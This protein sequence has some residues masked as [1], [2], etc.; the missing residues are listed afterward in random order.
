[1]FG[2]LSTYLGK[3]DKQVVVSYRGFRSTKHY[4]GRDPFPAL[5]ANGPINEQN[6][7]NVDFTYALTS[8]WN[9]SINVPLHFNSFSVRRS[10]PVTR[11][12]TWQK[13]E[14]SGAGDII[15]RV[16]YWTMSTE[17]DDHNIGVSVGVKVPTGKANRTDQVFTRTVPVDV[18]VQTGDKGWGVTAGAQGFQRIK[19]ATIYGS[20]SYLINPRNTNGVPTF[21]GSL[22]NPNN[23]VVNSVAD[24]FSTQAGVS[25]RLKRK[26]PVPSIAYRFEGVPV[27]D[28]IGSSDGFRRP[29]AFGFIE[30][31]INYGAGRHLFSFGVAIR[32]YVNVKDQPSSARVEDATIPKYMFFAAYS[33]RFK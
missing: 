1:M 14:S 5:D 15:L 18:S 6:Q 9:L 7:V 23:T 16:R 26:W 22:T 32:S 25:V 19:R 12:P 31:S 24:Q 20:A 10:D 17:Q 33:I 2:G 13:T 29:G 28:L 8:R 11:V 3:G 30:P 21:F 27:R 4:Q